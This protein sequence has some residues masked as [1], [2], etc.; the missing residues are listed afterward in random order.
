ML[1]A[2]IW[3]TEPVEILDWNVKEVQ[4]KTDELIKDRTFPV[5]VD[6]VGAAPRPV[7]SERQLNVL[8]VVSSVFSCINMLTSFLCLRNFSLS[9]SLSV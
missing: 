5:S 6:F 8:C 7:S 9:L 1:K 2:D 4:Y 3:N